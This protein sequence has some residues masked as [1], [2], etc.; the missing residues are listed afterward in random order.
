[1]EII[2]LL[3]KR[4]GEILPKISS[5]FE[6]ILINDGSRDESWEAISNIVRNSE[7]IFGI[8]L[9]RNYGQHN[10][11]LCGI[12][13]A[14]HEILVT[15]DDDFQ[16][17]PEEI[18]KLIN[19]LSE[20]YDVVYGT[21]QQEQH[22]IFRNLASQITKL[23]LKNAMGIDIARN[24]SSFRAFR[25]QVR[26]AFEYY[27]GPFI[28]IDVLLTWGTYRF[29]S[30]SVDHNSRESG[31]SNYNSLMLI[32]HAFNLITGFSTLPLRISS[33]LGFM[34][35]LF[36][37]GVFIYVVGLFL[38]QGY[39]IPGFPFLASIIAIFSGVQLF[40]LGVIGEYLA[41]IHF[42]TMD[43]PAYTIKEFID[44]VEK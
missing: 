22:G 21:P 40:A 26:E 30:I 32:S 41:R 39:S 23:A 29:S 43:K 18:P 20:G 4:L 25:K 7:D 15:M 17:P 1:M 31:K 3:V 10:A 35:T 9:M 11:I 44:N 27:H 13:H 34:F 36:G 14:K 33:L 2:P 28:S 12:R 37:I 8:N 42:R 19:K 16:N 5:K 38:I 24:I 6:I